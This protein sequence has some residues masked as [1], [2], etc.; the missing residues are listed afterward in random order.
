MSS[1]LL[2]ARPESEKPP[3]TITQFLTLL[4][5]DHLDAA[6]LRVRQMREAFQCPATV[7]DRAE[8]RNQ[9][10]A[11]SAHHDKWFYGIA[12]TPHEYPELVW[13][14]L[15][16]LYQKDF[17]D[18]ERQ[19]MLGRDGGLIRVIDELT[20]GVV[21]E[22]IDT[23]IDLVFLDYLPRDLDE[24]VVLARELLTHYGN[25]LF[26]ND[27]LKHPFLLA[28]NIEAFLKQFATHMHTMRKEWRL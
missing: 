18:A 25:V 8:F 13:G 20:D 21:K 14:H 15:R 24:K 12:S 3:I 16:R 7:A 28:V 26:P 1:L 17:Y 22:R 27:K 4:D 5:T 10:F 6:E 9:L 11:F 23:Y 2:V 19:A